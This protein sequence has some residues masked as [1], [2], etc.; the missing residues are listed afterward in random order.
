MLDALVRGIR[1]AGLDVSAEE[2]QDI[3]WLAERLPAAERGLASPDGST[4]RRN[5]SAPAATQE[6]SGAAP[7]AGQVPHI[8]RGGAPQPPVGDGAMPLHAQKLAG[9]IR[10]S[11]LRVPG[12]ASTGFPDELRRALQPFSRRVPS[13]WRVTLDEEA[14]A[15][16][17]A[18]AGV[19]SPVYKPA[20]QRWFDL[21]L[22]VEESPSMALWGET[23]ADFVKLLRNQGGFHSVATCRWADAKGEA[24]IL[25][26]GRGVP[27]DS[28]VDRSRPQLFVVVTDGI[29]S[30]WRDGAAS[31]LLFRLGGQASVSL[32]QVLPPRAWRH[33][34]LGEPE[35]SLF[36]ERAGEGNANMKVLLPWWLDPE[37]TRSALGVPVIGFDALTLGH[38]ARTMTAQGGACVPALMFARREAALPVPQPPAPAGS[39][40]E[41]VARYRAMV[42][43]EAYD[44]AVFLSVPDPL[45]V[46]VM[47]LVQRT[48]LPKTGTAELAEFFVGGLLERI[49]AQDNA[50]EATYRLVPGV[51]DELMRSLRYSEE[52]QID[53]QLRTVGRLLESDGG[54]GR[55]FDAYFP[56]PDGSQRLTKWSLPFASVSKGVLR[57]SSFEE[58]AELAEK[59]R[60]KSAKVR[61]RHLVYLAFALEE[62]VFAEMFQRV[63]NDAAKARGEEQGVEVYLD[64]FQADAGDGWLARSREA[65]RRSSVVVFFA[66]RRS[67]GSKNC[68]EQEVGVAHGLGKLIIPL[69]VED[70]AWDAAVIPG[71]PEHRRLNIYA[72]APRSQETRILPLNHWKNPERGISPVVDQL[73]EELRRLPLTDAKA[74]PKEPRRTA[75][76][77]QPDSRGGLEV[78]T[79]APPVSLYRVYRSGGE[80]LISPQP[81]SRHLS[82]HAPPDARVLILARSAQAALDEAV[83]STRSESPA[84]PEGVGENALS[85][86]LCATFEATRTLSVVSLAQGG[87]AHL[88]MGPRG[89]AHDSSLTYA[90]LDE[91][92]RSRSDI[93]G[94]R[95]TS[96]EDESREVLCLF[97]DRVRQDDLVLREIRPLLSLRHTLGLSMADSTLPSGSRKRITISCSNHYV[98]YGE[99]IAEILQLDLDV[100]ADTGTHGSNLEAVDGLVVVAGEQSRHEW[101]QDIRLARK[102]GKPA[103]AVIAD[104]TVDAPELGYATIANVDS[105]G[106]VVALSP[107]QGAQLL[108]II[109]F[110]AV[111]ILQTLGVDAGP[112]STELENT[113]DDRTA[114]YFNPASDVET[115]GRRLADGDFR[116]LVSQLSTGELLMGLY[117]NMQ[118]ALVATHVTSRARLMRLDIPS[119]RLLGFFA[120]RVEFE[121]SRFDPYERP[122]PREPLPVVD[123]V[124]PKGGTRL[125]FQPSKALTGELRAH[126]TSAFE[127]FEAYLRRCGYRPDTK[128]LRVFVD[129]QLKDNAY[130]ERERVVLGEPLAMDKDAF[131]R[132]CSHHALLRTHFETLGK[133]QRAIES[134]L[135]DYFPCSFSGDPRFAARSA[136]VFSKNPDIVSKGAIRLLDN[137]R[138]YDGKA[139]SWGHH[140]VGEI[141][142]GAFWEMRRKVGASIADRVLFESWNAC[143]DRGPGARDFKQRFIVALIDGVG[144]ESARGAGDVA[145]LFTARGF[146]AFSAQHSLPRPRAP[147]KKK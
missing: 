83:I 58:E 3:L 72:V 25:P 51:R 100:V 120:L 101:A 55:G 86:L 99:A 67:L 123:A 124:P 13:R 111:N 28:L 91:I 37:E 119:L 6:G 54:D 57:R 79:L 136:P 46:A 34:V 97:V 115:L 63:F 82:E 88:G 85:Q 103:I 27:I 17:A 110:T 93:D 108:P 117:E 142:G 66:S 96:G 44:L 52:G 59:L 5:E 84:F 64:R 22:V 56:T 138:C 145:A 126:L 38:W 50:D 125:V 1:A 143:L 65:I 77:S 90:T 11:T 70:C 107:M 29:S 4:P 75:A 16:Y 47:R 14:T 130:Y 140:D 31:N 8:G 121:D 80:P 41:K 24:V 135:A 112:L 9:T 98:G 105:S 68:M 81:L 23:L 133:D 122:G 134:G 146:G 15:E 139:K 10:A 30:R 40:A 53:E 109:R 92:H 26:D 141:W 114:R 144:L 74:E 113:H 62:L 129:P 36:V 104:A 43:S 78:M 33:S 21:R 94:V 131:F 2:L 69:L 35:L 49:P 147:K 106:R 32:L 102:L 118:S 20:R 19:W 76:T 39:A 87:S 61:P 116:G 73:L 95:L 60:A 18:E 7:Q 71:D 42:S 127:G 132:E 45:T 128:T 89:L 12:I 48:M 137:D